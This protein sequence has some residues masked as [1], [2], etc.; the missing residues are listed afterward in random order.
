M[1]TRQDVRRKKHRRRERRRER[2]ANKRKKR[3]QE[4]GFTNKTVTKVWTWNVQKTSLAANNRGRLRRILE[5]AW[6][7]RVDILLLTEITSK[8]DGIFWLGSEERRTVIIHSTKTAIALVGIWADLWLESGSRCWRKD[9]ATT[10]LVKNYRIMSVYQPLWHYGR[11]VINEYRYEIEEQIAMR[12]HDE[13]LIIGGDHNVSVGKLE[14]QSS[15]TKARGKY[16]CGPNNE[17]GND[18]IA[19]C[20]L[21]GMS[22]ANSFMSHPDRGTW[23]HEAYGRWYELDGFILKQ[24]QRHRIVRK[25]RTVK[26]N[27]FSDHR[28][29]ELITRTV[30]KPK[31]VTTRNERMSINH[32]ALKQPEKKKEFKERTER[33]MG[34]MIREGTVQSWVNLSQLITK[35]AA[36]VAGKMPKRKDSPWLEG[37]EAE[38][39]EEHRKITQ[40][41]N[42]LYSLIEALRQDLTEAEKE[43][44]SDEIKAKRE[45]RKRNRRNFKKKLRRW[46][47]AWWQELISQCQ[48][49]EKERDLG[50]MYQLLKKLGMRDS[51]SAS[52]N[53]YFTPQQYKA[54]FEK[55]SKERNEESDEMRRITIENIK[56]LREDIT[57]KEAAEALS[58]PIT[59]EEILREWEKVKDGAPGIDNVRISCIKLAGKTVQETV[60][61]FI[62]DMANK[63]PCEW[64]E[65]V[66]V[67]LVVPLFKKGQRNDIN[68]YRGVCLLSMASRILARIMASRLREWAEAVG[69]LDENQDG[70]RVGRL[71]ADA[72]QICIRLHEEA[73]LYVNESNNMEDWTPVA[74]LLDIKKAY[75]R[76][77]R[78]IL[79]CMLRKYGM[80]EESIRTLKGLHEET[81][82]RIKGKRE[83]SDAWQPL[84]G[85]REGCATSPILFNVYHSAAMR[86]A[87]EKRK[88]EAKERGMNVGIGMSWRPGNSLPPKSTAQAMKSKEKETVIITEALFAD[89]TTLYGERR[90]MKE[91]KEIVKRSMKNFEEQCHEGKEEHL[92]LGTSA[93]GEIR[94]L[95]TWIGR[96]Q[97]MQQRTK[98]GRF[99]LMTIKKR[100][101]NTTITKKTQA[102]IVQV[103]VESTML[104]NCETRAWQKKE[105]R[106][107]Q[108]VADQGYRYIWM[109]KR[110]GP[111]LKQM[112]EKRVNMW[113]VRRELEVRSMQAKIEERALRRMG[114]VLRMDNNRPTKQITLG[115]YTPPVTPILERKARHGTIEYWR[116]LLREAGLDADSVEHLVCDKGKWR[117][118]IHERKM[119]IKEWEECQAEYHGN[120]HSQMKRSQA[121]VEKQRSVVCQWTGC[122]K[123]LKSITGRKNHEK[124]HR[125]NRK[126]EKIC[127]WCHTTLREGTSL[128]SHQK[129]CMGAPKG[130]C[131]YCGERK[132][133]ANMA[134][135]KRT[136]AMG[137]ERMYTLNEEQKNTQ[138]EKRENERKG[139]MIQCELCNDFRSKANIS[140]HRRTCK[141]RDRRLDG[142][143]P[144]GNESQ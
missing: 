8:N 4:H 92:A 139:E 106:E 55:V 17:A 49:A 85:L 48:K 131:P 67:G 54:H 2:Q 137:N 128:T 24:E 52:A 27:S 25:I 44:K 119:Y 10:V 82:Y 114:H 86:Q 78:P 53:E 96:K 89:D 14:Q 15:T 42:E 113:G 133:V 65:M 11:K 93:G 112:E 43:K 40:I 75:P 39:Q 101:K 122:G 9:R 143:F 33:A 144:I 108:R 6:I 1:D 63:N 22:W 130:I 31:I 23:F 47:R 29:K 103:V 97:D 20:E 51:K 81:D 16:G 71:T 99:A 19:W 118:I 127:E 135:H 60:C 77:N 70:F 64:E 21:N 57:A 105:I 69:V 35:E 7:N 84:R 13:W 45:E 87:A 121:S 68:N 136:C 104:F 141:R 36:M 58:S 56:D 62:M 142:V 126:Q 95:G 34:K 88:Q 134:R 116:K 102:M 120:Q 41:S 90:E 79:W 12:R 100:L 66:K 26:E 123:V 76:V 107:L 61:N 46:E 129:Y 117:K 111:A 74:T 109:D 32:M 3:I 59:Q 98:R 50:T 138:Q 140:R 80:N 110:G 125:I 83:N 115:W 124:I 30:A 132:S 91:G 73:G 37:H 5:Y 38:I 94:M 18:L 28:P 72:T